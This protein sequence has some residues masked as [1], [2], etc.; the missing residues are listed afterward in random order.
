MFLKQTFTVILLQGLVKLIYS[1]RKLRDS[2]SHGQ[3]FSSSAKVRVGRARCNHAATQIVLQN[4]HKARAAVAL[5][6]GP[7][8]VGGNFS[9]Y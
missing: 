8:I 9:K 2:C 4:T 6:C 1:A 5:R 3:T 7:S